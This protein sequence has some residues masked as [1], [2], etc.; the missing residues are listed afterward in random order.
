MLLPL[1]ST[2]ARSTPHS[3][4]LN[5][6]DRGQVKRENAQGKSR[7]KNGERKTQIK[8][9]KKKRRRRRRRGGEEEDEALGYL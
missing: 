9:A 8:T 4:Q 2:A 7:E 3:H 5:D 6:A 1:K